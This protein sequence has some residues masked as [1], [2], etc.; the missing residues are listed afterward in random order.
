[1]KSVAGSPGPRQDECT[2]HSLGFE[3]GLK[4]V[5]EHHPGGVLRATV[6]DL[7]RAGLQDMGSY[8]KDVYKTDLVHRL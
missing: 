3:L 4:G 7:L 5:Q 8:S 6:D 1:M 2:C